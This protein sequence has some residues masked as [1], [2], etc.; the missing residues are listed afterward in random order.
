MSHIGT[1]WECE[2][3]HIETSESL[4]EE[5]SKCFATESFKR[6]PQEIHKEEEKEGMED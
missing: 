2:C 5:C 3:G 1:V 6:V 4:P